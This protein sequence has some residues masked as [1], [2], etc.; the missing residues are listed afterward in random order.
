[1]KK[2]F[3][4]K[5]IDIKVVVIINHKIINIFLQN[6][7]KAKLLIT[8]IITKQGKYTNKQKFSLIS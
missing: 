5:N 3:K 7:L 4:T 1:M 2:I 6:Q 8:E